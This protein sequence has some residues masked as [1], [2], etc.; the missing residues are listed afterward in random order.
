ME[1][2]I[3]Y[4]VE[5]VVKRYK[6]PGRQNTFAAV[7]KVNF[8]IKEG[9]TYGLVGESGCGKTTMVRMMMGLVEADEGSFIVNGE[10]IN[11]NKKEDRL[12]LYKSVQM[13][14]QDPYSSL[15]PRMRIYD[16]FKELFKFI[17]KKFSNKSF[18]NWVEELLKKVGLNNS[19]L[20]RYPFQLSGGQRQRIALARALSMNPKMLILDEAVSALDV[21]V[22][23]QILELMQK[24]QKQLNL[25]YLFIS[26]DLAVVSVL[27]DRVGIML[28]GILVEEGVSNKIFSSP[29][30]PYSSALLKAAK[31]IIPE[32]PALDKSIISPIIEQTIHCPFY[33]LC[34]SSTKECSS[35]LPE[36]IK[37]NDNN[38][39]RCFSPLN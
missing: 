9:E 31:E 29:S 16:I 17:N 32:N 37:L 24:L 1:S 25:T 15:N 26:H 14:F 20:D 35:S 23:A 2:P 3:F 11:W 39:V 33:S 19:F 36:F 34:A 21:S 10:T 13:V 38:K 12:R 4:K 5:N 27:A 8:A 30:H 28:K 18:N 6:I 7:D 22:Q